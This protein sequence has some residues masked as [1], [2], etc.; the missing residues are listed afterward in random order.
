MPCVS[1]HLDRHCE[2]LSSAISLSIQVRTGYLSAAWKLFAPML[3]SC[4]SLFFPVL[5]PPVGILCCGPPMSCSYIR[6]LNILRLNARIVKGHQWILWPAGGPGLAAGPP[7]RSPTRSA[8][9][10][11]GRGGPPSRSPTRSRTTGD[12]GLDYDEGD[13]IWLPPLTGAHFLCRQIFAVNSFACNGVLSKK[14]QA[15]T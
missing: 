14:R 6:S 4:T 8:T 1:F 2:S 11:H 9:T 3:V 12:L 15:C 5:C 13:S 7:G 10:G